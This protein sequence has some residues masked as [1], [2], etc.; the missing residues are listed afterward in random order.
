MTIDKT[1]HSHHSPSDVPEQP[2]AADLFYA[3][4]KGIKIEPV[5]TQRA[6]PHT[7][8]VMA[9]GL[10]TRM[11]PLT[12]DTPKP[13]I[14]IL[15]KPL[16][17]YTLEELASAGVTKAV[18]NV[19]YYADQIQNYLA[20]FNTPEIIISDERTRLLETGGG[21]KKARPLLGEDPVFCAN[22]DAI[23]AGGP[24]GAGCQQL[25]NS[26]GTDMLALLL[27]CPIE[28]TLGFE[29]LGDFHMVEQNSSVNDISLK[30]KNRHKSGKIIKAQ[31]EA[32]PFAFTGFQIIHPSLLDGTPSG[33]FSTRL[34]WQKAAR[35]NKLY[36]TIYPYQ[37]LHVGTPAGVIQAQ[38]HLGS[39]NGKIQPNIDYSYE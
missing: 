11:M 15:N 3:S 27:L 36:G 38:D 18:V 29:G 32:A 13:L 37:W 21:L 10:G 2:S 25:A 39:F 30:N 20:P 31:G 19:H 28:Q 4:V 35:K 9:A 12:K 14:P 26:W 5:E 22:T 1:P 33:P 7:A 24:L 34:L 23:L 17:D 6:G 16:I 8:M